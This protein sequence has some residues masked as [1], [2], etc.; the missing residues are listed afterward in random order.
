MSEEKKEPTEAAE[1]DAPAAAATPAAA[2]AAAKAIAKDAAA[3]APAKP[4]IQFSVPAPVIL[5]VVVLGALIAGSAL[6][7]LLIAPNVI[8]SRQASAFSAAMD[9][10][11]QDKQKKDKKKDKKKEKGGKEGEGKSTVYRIDNVIVNPANSDGQRFLMCAIAVQSD[12]SEL[13][14]TLREHEIELRDRIVTLLGAE[15]IETLTAAGARDSLRTRISNAIRPTLGEEAA[16]AEYQV[17][18]P[19]FVVQ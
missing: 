19:Q 4:K 18:L 9:P 8:H 1:A 13:L 12:D 6:G 15:T 10:H 17:Y 11:A 16:T 14:A 5:A 3:A 7:A 2:K